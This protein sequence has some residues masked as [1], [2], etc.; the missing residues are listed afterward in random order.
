MKRAIMLPQLSENVQLGVICYLSNA[1]IAMPQ[2]NGK[3]RNFILRKT[4][5]PFQLKAILGKSL[6]SV[7][8]KSA[9]STFG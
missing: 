6:T 5:Y 1:S 2:V 8:P 9:Q 7:L 3:K 4:F